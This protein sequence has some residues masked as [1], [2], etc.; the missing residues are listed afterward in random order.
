MQVITC[1]CCI[2]DSPCLISFSSRT[3]SLS[4]IGHPACS[5]APMIFSLFSANDGGCDQPCSSLDSLGRWVQ[6]MASSLL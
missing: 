3:I 5:K 1:T 6:I 4:L 2:Y